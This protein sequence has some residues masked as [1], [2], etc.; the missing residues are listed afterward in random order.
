MIRTVY[1]ASVLGVVT[2]F[3][4]LSLGMSWGIAIANIG[5]SSL[6]SSFTSVAV[7]LGIGAAGFGLGLLFF[8][9]RVQETSLDILDEAEQVVHVVREDVREKVTINGA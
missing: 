5:I 9:T 7:G 3:F 8:R 1:I 6:V 2:F 4:A